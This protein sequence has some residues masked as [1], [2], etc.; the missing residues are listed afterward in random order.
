VDVAVPA[1]ALRPD[2]GF[3]RS[4]EAQAMKTKSRGNSF[5]A[6]LLIFSFALPQ[7]LQARVEPTHGFDLFSTQEEVQAGKEAAAQV[8]KQL[9]ELPDSDPV[10]KYVQRLGAE[11]ASHAPGEKWPYNFHVVN[12]KEINAF[13]LPGGPV[14]INVGTVQAADNEAEL[15]G[16]M[17]HE[18]SHVVQR[19]GTRAASKQM[20]AQLPLALLGGIMGQG[21]LASMAAMGISFGVGSYFLRNSRQSEKEADLLGTDIMWDAGFDP[22]AMAQF[23]TKIQQEG[24]ARAPQFLSDHPD[25]GNRVEYVSAEVNTLSAKQYRGDSPDFAQ[26]KQLVAKMKPLTADQIAARQKAGG[27]ESAGQGSMTAP[28]NEVTASNNLRVFDHSLFQI[29][30]PDNWQVYGDQNSAVTIAPEGGVTQDAIAY[31]VMISAYQPEDA[32]QSLDQDTHALID[33]LHQSNPDL[34]LIGN[35]ESI[36]VNGVAGRSADLIGS[37][38]IRDKNG[39]PVRERDWLVTFK[40]SDGNLIYLVFITPDSEFMRL[41]PGFE[42]MLKTFRVR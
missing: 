40:L 27:F 6:V 5:L 28:T 25:P 34:R 33:S 13:A 22:H 38:P 30:Y 29:S 20:A 18:I 36:R 32:N 24:G 4:C 42:R 3:V 19:H 7:S 14:F 41:R 21:A 8:P 11:L 37:S 26:I 16:V 2:E 9:P 35:D 1:A 39:K 23:F 17:A 10:V 15:A 12:Q 31:G